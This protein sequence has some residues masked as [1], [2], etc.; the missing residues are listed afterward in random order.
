MLTTSLHR[1][2]VI[3]FALC[4]IAFSSVCV[5]G[6]IS[7]NSQNS[8]ISQSCGKALGE[9]L[10]E[11]LTSKDIPALNW[12][13]QLYLAAYK[14]CLYMAH[15]NKLTYEEY[16]KD[17]LYTGVTV[18]ERLQR[19][20]GFGSDFYC[21]ELVFM[22]PFD[23]LSL[24]EILDGDASYIAQEAL[25]TI[26]SYRRLKKVLELQWANFGAA[27]VYHDKAYWVTVNFACVYP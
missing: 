22:I 18:F 3:I 15:N 10:N 1:V 2:Y 5:N 24:E 4:W 20:T 23:S 21:D 8:E 25:E 19:S 26:L 6:Q 14:H 13:N 11:Y 17:S 16:P 12:S 7:V 9:V 27:F